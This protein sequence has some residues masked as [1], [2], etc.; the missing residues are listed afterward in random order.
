VNALLHV[1]CAGD[2][3]GVLAQNRGE[4]RFQYDK[5]W[6]THGFDLAPGSMKFDALANLAPRSV[7]AGLHGP[8]ND[9]LPDG[10]GLLLMERALK[11]HN[12]L[13]PADITPLHRLA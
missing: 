4:I 3:V 9:S 13:D 1:R 11:Q 6:L 8:F 10:W 2:A 7:F 5:G 12:N